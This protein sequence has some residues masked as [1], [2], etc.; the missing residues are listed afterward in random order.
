MEGEKEREVEGVGPGDSSNSARKEARDDTESSRCIA[1][2]TYG[3][4]IAKGED[5][6]HK[7]YYNINIFI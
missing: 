7:I 3:G 4:D 6:K 2:L 1:Y 5:G